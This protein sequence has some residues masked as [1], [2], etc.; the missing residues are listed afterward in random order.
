MNTEDPIN[1]H[2]RRSVS[3][4][5]SKPPVYHAASTRSTWYAMMV[6]MVLALIVWFATLLWETSWGGSGVSEIVRSVVYGNRETLTDDIFAVVDDPVP[7]PLPV[8]GLMPP[9][10]EGWVVQGP[11]HVPGT[12]ESMVEAYFN[13]RSEEWSHV[14]PLM[15]YVRVTKSANAAA[16]A[17]EPASRADERYRSERGVATIAGVQVEV[18]S[19]DDGS[20]Y[21]IGWSDGDRVYT[22]EALF[23]HVV[24]VEP[25]PIVSAAA[26]EIAAAV[27]DAGEGVSQ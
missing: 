22:V 19:A 1:L 17:L 9:D 26:E 11:H 13:P 24:P 23:T 10:L 6:V 3:L 25:L 16:A 27:L 2:A 21:Y 12:G 15:V 7:D 20:A 5:T 4:T 14:T 18:G 8:T